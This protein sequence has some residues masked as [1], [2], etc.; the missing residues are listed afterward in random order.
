MKVTSVTYGMSNPDY[1]ADP[2]I[3]SSGFKLMERSPLHYWSAYRDPNRERR[4][5]TPAMLIGSAWHCGIFEPN[6]FDDRYGIKPDVSSATTMGKALAVFLSGEAAWAPYTAI[7][8]GITKA[9]KDGKA[10][11]AELEAEG[12]I[13]LEQS[14]FDKVVE[15]GTPL[16]GKDLFDVDTFDR[17]KK[18]CA[19]AH[20]HPLANFIFGRENFSEA[21]IF[22][23][24]PETGVRCK[25]RPDNF[26]APCKEFPNGLIIDGKTTD[27]ASPDGFAKAIWNWDMHYQAAFYTDGFQY[28]FE[29]KGD[30]L[31][32]WMAQEKDA[33]FAT[34]FYTAPGKLI[35]YGRKLYRRQ[36][37]RLAEC[38]K[39]GVWP[40]YSNA[41]TTIA[42]PGWA[43]KIVD[44]LVGERA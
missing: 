43:E 19:S 27:D 22:W 7:P 6:E 35:E 3:G 11:H 14:V 31:F 28:V 17:I 8:D 41:V 39:T 9:S 38:E 18:M 29:T 30:P 42:L 34:A 26:V 40:G 5:A 21:S 16:R 32:C 24:D 10:L 12:K 15:L 20:A 4:E 23:T 33:P 25:I 44:D 2:A 1:H 36:M 13:G 37:R